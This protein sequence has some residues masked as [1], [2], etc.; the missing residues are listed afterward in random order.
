MQS[1]T[2][3]GATPAGPR[4]KRQDLEKPREAGRGLGPETL[5]HRLDRRGREDKCTPRV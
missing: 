2:R 1:Q 5:R 4:C 3:S